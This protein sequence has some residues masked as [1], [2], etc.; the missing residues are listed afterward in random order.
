MPWGRAKSRCAD[1]RQEGESV[2]TAARRV[3]LALLGKGVIYTRASW[4]QVDGAALMKR[5]KQGWLMEV[6]DSLDRCIER[7]RYGVRLGG[8]PGRDLL[9]F[10]FSLV[11]SAHVGEARVHPWC[12][13]TWSNRLQ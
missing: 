13:Y 7:L 11:P 4:S 2:L 8:R 10:C 9:N 12:P 3:C 1:A 5:H 6:T